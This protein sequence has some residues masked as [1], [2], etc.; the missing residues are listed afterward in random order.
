ME[1][2][3]CFFG[4]ERGSLNK[5]MAGSRE[6]QAFWQTLTQSCLLRSHLVTELKQ[7]TTAFRDLCLRVCTY[8]SLPEGMYI[9]FGSPHQTAIDMQ[10]KRESGF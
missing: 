6:M 2:I 8:F 5:K 7:T 3:I 9:F 10:V 1:E 4:R